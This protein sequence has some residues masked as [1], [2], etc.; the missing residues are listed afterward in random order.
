MPAVP[1]GH[2]RQGGRKEKGDV[3]ISNR[4]QIR[5][6]CLRVYRGHT[7]QG[8]RKEKGD[9]EISNRG[10]NSVQMPAVPRDKKTVERER[11]RG[12]E[13]SNR[14]DKICENVSGPKGSRNTVELEQE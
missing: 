7:R 5:Y 6:R 11:K 2:T 4:G 14:G 10:T 8:G 9:V 13:I 3:D 12:V 1:R